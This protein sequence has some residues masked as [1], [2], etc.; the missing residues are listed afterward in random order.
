MTLKI[1]GAGFGR[2]GTYSLKTALEK[3]GFGPCHHMSEVVSNPVQID[4]WSQ[5]AAGQSNYDAAFNGFQSAVDFPGSAFWRE[6]L[7]VSPDAKVIL[8]LRDAEDWYES[9]SQTILPLIMDRESWPEPARPWFEMMEKVIIGKALS[10][11]T[12]RDGILS[13]Y[14][15]NENAAMRLAETGRALVFR[16]ADGWNP[17]CGFLGAEVPDES[18]PRTNPRADFFAAVKSGTDA[19]GA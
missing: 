12:D 11:R 16:S 17:L 10:G 19:T 6:V 18:Y 13:A 8:S 7:A 4:L 15:E 14:R 2:T 3:L 1:I 9:F 5:A